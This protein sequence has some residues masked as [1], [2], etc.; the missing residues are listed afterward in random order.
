MAAVYYREQMHGQATFSLF[1]RKLP[2]T[3]GFLV[4]AGLQNVLDYLQSF[5]FSANTLAH[6]ESLRMFDAEFIAFLRNLRFTGSVRAAPEG[7]VI[8]SDEPLLEV[9]AP[10]IEAQLVETVILNIVHL[11]T[12]L[13]SKAAR[14]VL[15]AGGRLVVEFGLRRTHGLETGLRAAR[16]AYIAGA[17]MTS[18]VLAQMTYGIPAT[19]TMAHSFVSAF[20]EETD[21]FRAFAKTFPTRTTLL[22][23]TYDTISGAHK[24]VLVAKEM[25]SHGVQLASVRLD[26]GDLL[27]LSRAVRR[28]LDEANLS[29]VKIFASGGLDEYELA[30]LVTAGAP[31]D[32]FGVGTHMTTSADAPYLDMA[33]KLV[34]YDGRDVLK[35][36]EGKETWTGEKQVYRTT[37]ADGTFID[38]ELRLREEPPPNGASP[39][40]HEVM[41]GGQQLRAHPSLSTVREHCVAEL[42]RLPPGVRRLRDFAPYT[43]HYGPGLVA[44]QRG[45]EREASE[46]EICSGASSFRNS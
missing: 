7:T 13:A 18:D 43:V 39:L 24:A 37:D 32:A 25:E 31:I 34:R 33:Y 38:D 3:R 17:T 20:P 9:T 4:A 45:L 8:F 16:C 27:A 41:G 42:R 35:L 5:R 12:V 6:L 26:S 46:R 40:L 2:P 14:V 22:L 19:G 30:R 21:A 29:Y 44:L 36:S 15:A 11:E 10:I 1:S 28:I 23:D